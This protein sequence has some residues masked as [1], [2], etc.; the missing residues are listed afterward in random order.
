MFGLASRDGP[1]IRDGQATRPR[2]YARSSRTPVKRSPSRSVN[3]ALVLLYRQVGHR[4]HADVLRQE[5]AA[6]GEEI[7]PTPSAQ[8][9]K[10]FGRGLGRRNDF[11][12]VRFVRGLSRPPRSSRRC[13]DNWAGA[14]SL[15]LSLWNLRPVRAISGG[16]LGPEGFAFECPTG[17]A[18]RSGIRE[19]PAISANLTRPH[20]R[21][22]SRGTAEIEFDPPLLFPVGHF[23]SRRGVASTPRAVLFLVLVFPSKGREKRKPPRRPRNHRS[24]HAWHEARSCSSDGSECRN[25]AA[26][27][28]GTRARKRAMEGG[29]PE[30][31]GPKHKTP[32]NPWLGA[33]CCWFSAA[34][35]DGRQ[36]NRYRPWGSIRLRRGWPPALP[37][38]FAL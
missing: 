23:S 28:S 9:E 20:L 7:V 37:A 3:T 18:A 4:I 34:G 33:L 1:A 16:T 11:R 29:E 13:R 35:A 8:L 30:Q 26:E 38:V 21:K 10:E 27:P 19:V 15:S 31:A 5:R 2:F 12:M 32:A 22:S 6:Y 17:D 14:I 24:E 25:R 36:G